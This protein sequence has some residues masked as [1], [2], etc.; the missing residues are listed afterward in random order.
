MSPSIVA[1]DGIS[2]PRGLVTAVFAL[3]TV[4]LVWAS[5]PVSLPLAALF[6]LATC[7]MAATT[8]DAVRDHPSFALASAA[9]GAALFGTL[10]AA[11]TGPGLTFGSTTLLAVLTA[12]CVV[13]AV[14]ER[15]NYRNGTSYLR[16]DRTDADSR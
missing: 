4:V 3:V 16:V 9:Y 14:V 12:V 15:Y 2:T 6:G 11:S 8:F 1:R 10:A 5:D 7:Y 13:G